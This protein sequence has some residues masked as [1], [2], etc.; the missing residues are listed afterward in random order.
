RRRALREV[1]RYFTLASEMV[2]LA[3]FDGYWT[4]VNPAVEAVL[5]DSEREALARPGME[6]VHPGD[7]ERS[8]Q[9][10]RRVI[11]GATAHGVELRMLCKDGSYKW[12]EWTATPIPEERMMYGIGRDVTERRRSESEQRALQRLST[13]GAKEVPQADVFAAIVEESAALLGTQEVRMLRFEGD[14]SA[15]VVGSSGRRDAFPLASRQQLEGDSVAARVRRTGQPVRIDDYSVP[16]G[17]L[18]ETARSIGVR[19]VV[20]VPV[21]VDELL[22]GAIIAGST[23][24]EPLPPDTEAR[25]LHFMELTAT[26]ISNA[27]ARDARAVLAEEQA[28]LRRVATLVAYES[29]PVATFSAVTTEAAGVLEC[30]AVG[31]LRFEPDETATLVAQSDTPWDPPPLGTR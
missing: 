27:E 30:D 3:G 7:R 26:A 15:V 31:L 14:T 21:C 17:S 23:H 25:L 1:D 12:I 2:T 19:A 4:R 5:G 29:S 13:L 11:E 24:G 22:W 20:G 10:K 9:E 16:V 6:L 28:A 18:A 8:G